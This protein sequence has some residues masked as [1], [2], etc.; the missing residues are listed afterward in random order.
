MCSGARPHIHDVVGLLHHILVVLHHNYRVAGVAQ[1]LERCDELHVVALVQADAGLIQD[2]EH[3]YQLQ[4]DLRGQA[5]AL[6]LAARQR[7][8]AAAQR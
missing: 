5:D 4:S 2:V 1:L 8:R 7:A 6:A 3:V